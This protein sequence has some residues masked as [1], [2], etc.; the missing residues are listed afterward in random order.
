MKCEPAERKVR[1]N[2]ALL[3]EKAR[4]ADF[5]SKRSLQLLEKLEIN[6]NFFTK[7]PDEWTD[8]Q[9][10]IK[11]QNIIRNLKVV[12]DLAERAV[13]LFEEFNKLL[14][15]DEDEKQVLLQVIE[16]NRKMVPTKTTKQ[17][18]VDS[19]KISTKD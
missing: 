5:A 6:T 9:E 16:A 3:T 8:D 10:Y 15:N 19:L 7:N 18:I 4:L 11:G 1:G 2:S 17:A 14:T 13:K 12:N